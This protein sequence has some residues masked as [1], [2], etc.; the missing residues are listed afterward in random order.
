MHHE[1][2]ELIAYV[3]TAKVTDWKRRVLR[4][5]LES[6]RPVYLYRS[7]DDHD[8]AEF[9]RPGAVLWIVE[10][11]R[12]QP[13]SL[14]ARLDVIGQIHAEA[15]LEIRDREGE[16]ESALSML[17]S[18]EYHSTNRWY[19]VGDPETSRFYGLNDFSGAL[20][21][22]ELKGGQPWEPGAVVWEPAFG[23]RFIRPRRVVAGQSALHDAAKRLRTRSIFVS[24]K[25]RDFASRP[26]VVLELVNQLAAAG[27]D[28]W[29][30]HRAMPRSRALTKLHHQPE[31]LGLLLEDGLNHATA[32]LA[33]GSDQYG[34]PSSSISGRNWTLGEWLQA[35]EM[36]KELFVWERW[37]VPDVGWPDGNYDDLPA[38]WDSARF[39]RAIADRLGA[40]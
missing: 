40:T 5:R 39:A 7:D 13:P 6:G 3:Q 9:A 26:G 11:H 32:L 27:L 24:W 16:T 17:R 15:V 12:N 20:L 14:A 8:F 21:S 4:H 38:E 33:L 10:S 2:V 37:G 25:H 28:C 31:L 18:F 34:Q 30:D 29:W 1:P 35:K 23:R 22:T 36:A 19:A